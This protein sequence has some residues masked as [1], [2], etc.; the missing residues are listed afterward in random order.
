MITDYAVL[1]TDVQPDREIIMQRDG[2]IDHLTSVLE[3]ITHGVAPNGAFVHG[4]PGAGKT[5]AVRSVCSELERVVYLDCLGSHSRR[6]VLNRVLEGLGEGATLER[7]SIA[8]DDLS[9][10]VRQAIEKPTVV[11]LDEA[12][13]IDELRVLH[14]LYGIPDLTLVLISN[15]SWREFDLREVESHPRLDSRIRALEEIPFSA[16]SDTELVS[17][18]EKRVSVGV[19]PG[20]VMGSELEYIARLAENDARVAI[21][22]LYHSVRAADRGGRDRV[23]RALID[24][25]KS[26]A[27]RDIIR[28]RLS[29]LSREQRVSLEALAEIAPATS[30]EMFHAYAECSE[31]AVRKRT[32]RGWLPKFKNYELVD[33]EGP[34]HEPRYSVREVV[35]EELGVVAR[36]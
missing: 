33:V 8:T 13:Q 1:Q 36:G 25:S 32:L 31:S 24:R 6:S 19:E 23:T 35:L 26:D 3:P 17:I 22:H 18:L 4:P 15:E 20:V 29:A 7:R 16:Y 5:C 27:T 28:S 14:E 2:Q 12:D 30:G 21:A 10:L 9:S 34:E 11:V